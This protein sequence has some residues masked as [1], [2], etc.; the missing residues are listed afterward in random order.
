MT[1]SEDIKDECEE[2]ARELVNWAEEHVK[3]TRWRFPFSDPGDHLHWLLDQGVKTIRSYASGDSP[4]TSAKIAV[5]TFAKFADAHYAQWMSR[6][7]RSL[8]GTLGDE[9]W[10]VNEPADRSI[11]E[12]VEEQSLIEEAPEPLNRYL[13]LRRDGYTIEDSAKTLGMRHYGH[14]LE[15]ASRDWLQGKE[16]ELSKILSF[17]KRTHIYVDLD[18]GLLFNGTGRLCKAFGLSCSCVSSKRRAGDSFV[19]LGHHIRAYT[20]NEFERLSKIYRC[21]SPETSFRN[22]PR[23]PEARIRVPRPSSPGVEKLDRTT[24]KKICSYPSL[25]AAAK[26]M[27]ISSGHISLCCD[28]KR[29]TAGG[30]GWRWLDE[31]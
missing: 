6:N 14:L 2:A 16:P 30:F 31:R 19:L 13:S 27:G 5:Y 17:K 7:K 4:Y 9:W 3:M 28:G 15:T 22:P 8:F 18:E 1:P 20:Q 24:G 12:M 10:S 11:S 21:W 29:H 23:M 26:E 25:G